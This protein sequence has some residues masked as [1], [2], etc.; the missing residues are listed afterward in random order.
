LKKPITVI[1]TIIGLI[2]LALGIAALFT[3][4]LPAVPLLFVAVVCFVHFCPPFVAWFLKR[5]ISKSFFDDFIKERSMTRKNKIKTL[6]LSTVI[7]IVF[8]FLCR[9]V[10][11]KIALVVMLAVEYYYFYFMV[12]FKIEDGHGLREEDAGKAPKDA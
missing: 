12:W 1:G 9:S 3:P 8:F 11:G 7:A 5:P 10:W 4:R 6:G 2:T